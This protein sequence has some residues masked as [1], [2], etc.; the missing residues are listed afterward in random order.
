MR[1]SQLREISEWTLTRDGE[2]SSLG[3]VT[4]HSPNMLVFLESEQFID[5]LLQNPDITCVV[6]KDDF[7][8]L[9]PGHI[10]I[11]ACD[12]PRKAFY[13]LHNYLATSTDF[14]WKTFP[15]RIDPTA[16]I[17]PRAYIAENDVVIG[18]NVVIEPNVTILQRVKIEGGSIIRSGAVIGSEGFQFPEI[19]GTVVPVVH[20]GSVVIGKRVEIQSNTCVDK[21][22]FGS[23]TRIGE[24]T[25]IDNLVHIAHDVKIGKQCRIIALAMIGGS[26]TIGDNVWVGPSSSIRP[27][28]NIGDG[29]FISM[30]SVVTKSVGPGQRVTGNFAID[31]SK[32]I[33]FMKAIR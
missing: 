3:F 31:H 30:G 12:S 28:L 27:E 15:T 16:K 22:V 29:A 25:R 14:Y 8:D 19:A 17:H 21:A 6:A 9:L 24:N 13:E 1:L 10:G 26:V 23:I 4:H 32:F 11:A 5:K 18:K 2:F 33:E 7:L 20:S